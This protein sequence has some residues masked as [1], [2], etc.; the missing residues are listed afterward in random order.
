MLSTGPGGDW[1]PAN[2]QGQG[3]LEDSLSC[4]CAGWYEGDRDYD[5]VAVLDL[6]LV[7]IEASA[8]T[9]GLFSAAREVSVQEVLPS[10]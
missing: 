4:P 8:A 7:M 2:S 1:G 3:A 9:T 10:P 6:V 5:C